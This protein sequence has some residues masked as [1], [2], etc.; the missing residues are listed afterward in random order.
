MALYREEARHRGLTLVGRG[1]RGARSWPH[2][3]HGIDID[4]RAV[5]IAAAGL[6]LKARQLAPEVRLRKVN[7]VAPALQLGGLPADDPAL[8][9]L[10]LELEREAGIPQ[11]LTMKL[12]GALA[13]VDHLGTLLKVDKAVEEALGAAE[14]EFERAHGQ[15]NLFDG[16]RQ[17]QVKLTLD[18][19]RATV[20]G[21]LEQFLARH[22][23]AGDLGLRLDGEQ[24]AA[25]VR[26]VR[27]V[28]EGAYDVVVGNPPYQALS[29]TA[30]SGYVGK[31]YEGGKADLYAAF[32]DR[33]LELVREGGFSAL[34]TMRGWMFLGQFKDL[35]RR[36]LR[37]RDLR[38]LGDVDRGAFEDVPDEILATVMSVVRLS[39][40]S[41][42]PASAIQPTPRLDH[43]RDSLRTA[44]KRAALLAHVGR[45]EFDSKGF[46]SIDGQPIVYWWSKELLE[47]YAG[48]P[49]LG[50][51]TPAQNGLSTQN[52]VR[53]LRKPWETHRATLF[54][55]RGSCRPGRQHSWFPYIKGGEGDEWC[56]P[57]NWVV[58][59][60]ESGLG[61]LVFLDEYQELRPG[62]YIKHQDN[63]FRLGVA[64]ATIGNTFSARAHRF[65]SIFG[66][67][68]SSVFPDSPAQMVCLMNSAVSRQI[69]ES[70]NPGIGFEVGDVNR[71]PVFSI[72]NADA[73]YAVVDLAFTEH[74]AAR[75]PS[76]EFT[77]PGR[78]PWRYA[79]DWAQR[80][81]D[82]P[83]GIPI[84]PYTPEYDPT[85]P[86]SFVSFAFGVALSRFG[87]NGEGILDVAPPLALP[88]GI[89]FLSAAGADSLDHPACTRLHEAW[90]EVGPSVGGGDNLRSYLAESFFTWHRKLY[91]SR[92]I[93]FPLS[94]AKRSFVAFVSIHR[95]R[96]DTLQML[97]AE[98][99]VPALRRLEGELNDLQKARKNGATKN[100][101]ERRFAEVQKLIE[102][103]TGFI[104]KVTQVQSTD[105]RHPK[106]RFSARPT[107]ASSWISTTA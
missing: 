59:W 13:G 78:S 27:M 50:V 82:Q 47:R 96:E 6:Y 15:G 92:P 69:L 79:Q 38:V 41:R 97:R 36:I 21:K 100:K 84:A 68:G 88:G 61:L 55:S 25:G 106:A 83:N 76:V 8:A 74:E 67:K 90:K 29:K 16:F 95:W 77:H 73:I 85:E 33:G 23:A 101:A 17:Q 19:A 31:H 7:L 56:E 63:Y 39:T 60:Y 30:F 102:E 58:P 93:Y 99:L 45:S 48:C 62:G 5:Q 70:L 26:F 3:L 42:L 75:E 94:S 40:P 4:P 43:S 35:R 44:R 53:F 81:V 71:L 104:D 107:P 20:L 89:L 2:N 10:C 32:L 72:A 12:I 65:S 46:E 54:V 52:N 98:H 80:A 66:H 37:T 87:A 1:D 49:K 34:L 64:F 103:L 51:I 91:E 86:T 57:L 18:E 28:R 14:L 24:L 11:A 105:R 9:D 22:S